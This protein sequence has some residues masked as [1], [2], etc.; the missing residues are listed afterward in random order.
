MEERSCS[1]VTTAASVKARC[2]LKA[3]SEPLIRT[4]AGGARL[5]NG[6]PLVLITDPLHYA[7]VI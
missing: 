7:I 1:L 2:L 3:P 6:K 5:I 4:A